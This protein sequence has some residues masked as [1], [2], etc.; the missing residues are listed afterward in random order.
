VLSNYFTQLNVA[1]DCT[2]ST[3]QGESATA[4]WV[5]QTNGLMYF[6]VLLCLMTDDIA[7][8]GESAGDRCVMTVKCD[9]SRIFDLKVYLMFV[10]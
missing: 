3:G 5:N 9:I 2:A 8:Q 10:N 1:H 7:H 4:Q 6:A